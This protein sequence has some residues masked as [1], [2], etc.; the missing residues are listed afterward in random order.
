[1]VM[2]GCCCW[3]SW[4]ALMVRSWR[5]C[6][7]HQAKRSW[8]ASP[9]A[10]GLAAPG[11]AVAC[12][13]AGAAGGDGAAGALQADRTSGRTAMRRSQ[14]GS[15]MRRIASSPWVKAFS[16]GLAFECRPTVR[17]SQR[18]PRK[19][20]CGLRLWLQV[21]CASSRGSRRI[22]CAGADPSLRSGFQDEAFRALRMKRL[23]CGRRAEAAWAAWAARCA[24]RLDLIDQ[25]ID[26]LID[27]RLALG[28]VGRL[29]VPAAD[30]LVDA[31]VRGVLER[32]GDVVGALAMRLCHLR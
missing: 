8:T 9:L 30:L 16:L 2:F 26:A 1:M 31:L 25:L 5:S 4:I 23:L 21:Y 20:P 13:W 27:L 22:S 18:S 12:C 7:P 6:E 11:A 19:P 15:A 32:R 3:N 14:P 10:A 28:R 24:L 17:G 29:D